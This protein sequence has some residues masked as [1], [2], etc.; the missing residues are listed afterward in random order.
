M[1]QIIAS[2]LGFALG[3]LLLPALIPGMRVRGMGAALKVGLVCGVLSVLL[4]KLLMFV[5]SIIFLLPIV[6][7]GPLGP[8]LVQGLVNGIL[9]AVATRVVSG[10]E[11]ERRRSV[12]WA[13]LAL[14][15]LQ[16]VVRH[17]A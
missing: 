8:L 2:V 4:G 5:L 10:I 16:W 3:L 11:F 6:L 14:T 17:L 9:L 15:I 1:A 13:A 12:A 7:L